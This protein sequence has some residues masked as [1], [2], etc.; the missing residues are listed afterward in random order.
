MPEESDESDVDNW[1]R[2]AEEEDDKEDN[3]VVIDDEDDPA[4][5]NF[6]KPVTA[7]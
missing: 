5:V 3:V 4:P 6:G 2:L 7:H 1:E